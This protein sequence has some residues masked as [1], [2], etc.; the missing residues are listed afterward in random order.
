[1]FV[2]SNI[3]FV[4]PLAHIVV[5]CLD[6][7]GSFL[8]HSSFMTHMHSLFTNTSCDVVINI[9]CNYFNFYK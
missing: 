2:L 7:F 5:K 8:Y 6:Q 3:P 4:C 9:Y 1:M